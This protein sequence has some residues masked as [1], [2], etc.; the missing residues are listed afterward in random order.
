MRRYQHQRQ[1]SVPLTPRPYTPTASSISSEHTFQ[2]HTQ[3]ATPSNT[4]PTSPSARTLSPQYPRRH[5][6]QGNHDDLLHPTSYSRGQTPSPCRWSDVIPPNSGLTFAVLWDPEDDMVAFSGGELFEDSSIA[7][8]SPTDACSQ[9]LTLPLSDNTGT[10]TGTLQYFRENHEWLF[11]DEHEDAMDKGRFRLRASLMRSRDKLGRTQT[12]STMGELD[13]YLRGSLM[14]RAH[15]NNGKFN[16]CFG[17]LD[18]DFDFDP[19]TEFEEVW[20]R[21]M[22]VLDGDSEVEFVGLALGARRKD[23]SEQVDDEGFFEVEFSPKRP[24]ALRAASTSKLS[25]PKPSGIKPSNP[26][27]QASPDDDT[28]SWQSVECPNRMSMAYLNLIHGEH[29]HRKLMKKRPSDTPAPPSEVLQRQVFSHQIS[30]VPPPPPQSSKPPCS[31]IGKLCRSLSLK[32]KKELPVER[33]TSAGTERVVELRSSF[34]LAVFRSL[35]VVMKQST[36]ALNLKVSTVQERNGHNRPHLDIAN[37]NYASPTH[38]TRPAGSAIPT[39]DPARTPTAK[40]KNHVDIHKPLPPVS[41]G[42]LDKDDASVYSQDSGCV[43]F[44]LEPEARNCADATPKTAL[45]FAAIWDP[46]A[47][48][49]TIS[50]GQLLSNSNGS[51]LHEREDYDDDYDYYGNGHP[52]CEPHLPSRFSV[53]TTSTSNYIDIDFGA[54]TER[55]LSWNWTWPGGKN[56]KPNAP[57]SEYLSPGDYHPPWIPQIFNAGYTRP[58]ESSTPKRPEVSEPFQFMSSRKPNPFLHGPVPSSPSPPPPPIRRGSD[59]TIVPSEAQRYH[60]WL[61]SKAGISS[62]ASSPS[63]LKRPRL[64]SVFGKLKRS[65]TTGNIPPSAGSKKLKRGW[66]IVDGTGKMR[67]VQDT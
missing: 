37:F 56:P 29:R 2:I 19:R 35:Q 48:F 43:I 24:T 47:G 21:E 8:T 63:S 32:K 50:G 54:A 27:A 64:P 66:V 1:P 6:E 53:T 52:D 38:V 5:H 36:R 9:V 34:N 15:P 40:H 41:P 65:A 31:P 23:C 58:K 18:R 22:L 11:S 51:S 46:E 67:S 33:W 26:S 7:L 59:D 25:R 39:M 28:R 3:E 57:T 20:G 13:V 17:G 16:S 30:I 55:D 10:C 4:P 60:T 45:T 61:P 62:S 49:T 12:S 44:E 14:G 42:S